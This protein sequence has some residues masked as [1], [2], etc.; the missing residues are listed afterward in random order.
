MSGRGQ[1]ARRYRD[2]QLERLAVV[3]KIDAAEHPTVGGRDAVAVEAGGAFHEE[4][5]E[6]RL[7]RGGRQR[8]QA[9]APCGDE[10]VAKIRSSACRRRKRCRGSAARGPRG[11]RA[12]APGALACR[13]PG[14]AEGHQHEIARVVAALHGDQAQGADHV[15]VGD[16]HDAGGG[17]DGIERRAAWPRRRRRPVGPRSASS[18][19]SPPRKYARVQPAQHQVRVRDG[20][21]RCRRGRSRRGP[22]GRR[23][24][25]GPRAA[26]PAS[27][28]ASLPPPR[29]PPP[30]RSRACAPDSPRRVP[31]RA[32]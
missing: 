3:A 10:L 12:R 2:G 14:A 11:R 1:R 24:C 30:G 26:P 17:G 6:Q 16:L 31:R 18:A 29:R 32:A 19:I 25:A 5:G 27:I 28:H 22:G 8:V 13:G 4:L 23:R 21:R 9:Q 15:G 7:Q 20:R